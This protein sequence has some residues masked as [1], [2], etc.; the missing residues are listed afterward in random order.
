MIKR[1]FEEVE[2]VEQRFYGMV[3]DKFRNCIKLAKSN[4]VVLIGAVKVIE[5]GDY[6]LELKKQPKYM[7][8]KALGIINDSI[9]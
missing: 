5:K 1:E 3:F 8:D 9:D 2:K 6:V 4:P 7:K